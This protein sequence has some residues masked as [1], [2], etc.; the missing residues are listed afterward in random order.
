MDFRRVAAGTARS[1]G[2]LPASD[3][4]VVRT[5]PPGSLEQVVFRMDV[6]H[7]LQARGVRMLNPPARPGN[8]RRQVSGSGPTGSG[9]AA[10][11]AD[12]RL[13][14]CRR[15]LEAFAALGGDV[16]VKPL[17]GSEGRGI[18]RVTDPELAWRT[19][20][21]LERLKAVLYVAA[22]HPPS[23]L[24]SARLRAGPAGVDR[25]AAACPGRLAHQ[26]RSGRQGRT[27][28]SDAEEERLA[29]APPQPSGAAVRGV[30]LL[31]GPDGRVVR[32]GGQRRTRLVRAGPGDWRG[33]GG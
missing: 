29:L 10:R 32:P 5:M 3:A 15:R 6:L 21:T 14:A 8:L 11:T 13:S 12:H 18:V 24:G 25:H 31:P 20:R 2:S 33:R 17:F 27:R 19:F 22:I 7:R 4:V 9:R 28:P 16:V 26:R 30:D 23:R 1:G